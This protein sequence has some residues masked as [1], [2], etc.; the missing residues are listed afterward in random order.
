MKQKNKIIIL[1][2]LHDLRITLIIDI[3]ITAAAGAVGAALCLLLLKDWPKRQAALQGC[4]SG[5]LTAGI[6]ALFVTAAML[7]VWRRKDDS[8]LSKLWHEK[9]RLFPY[10]VGLLVISIV[11]LAGGILVDYLRCL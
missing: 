3:M 10:E 6:A 1:N 11:P 7:L 5:L 9:F 8:R 2:F 4:A